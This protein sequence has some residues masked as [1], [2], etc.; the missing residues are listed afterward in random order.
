MKNKIFFKI[1]AIILT[2]IIV[3]AS[4]LIFVITPNLSE[5]IIDLEK[6]QAKTQLKRVEA[7]IKS[8]EEYLKNYRAAKQIEHKDNLRDISK[9]VSVLLD[10]YY[11]LYEEKL[12][13]KEEA[14]KKAFSTVSNIKY[15]YEDDYIYILDK[16]GKV[17]LH[18]QEKYLFQNVYDL[19]DKKEK[20]FIKKLIEDTIKH[21]EFF[22]NYDWGENGDKKSNKIA[23]S[24]YYKPFDLI[25]VSSI[26]TNDLE[27]ELNA[28]K[29][30]T[31]KDLNP[32]IQSITKEELGYVFIMDKKAQL[33]MHPN[34]NIYS[35]KMRDEIKRQNLF[36][37]MKTAYKEKKSLNYKWDKK[38]DF[39][40]FTYDKTAWIDY[41]SF[42]GWYISSSLYIDD[43]EK[44]AKE[45]DSFV[46]NISLGF[47]FVIGLLA[48]I[49]LK[50][51]LDPISVLT[52]NAVTAREGNL[53]VRNKIET[54]DELGILAKQFNTMLDSIENNTKN[55]EKKLKERTAEIEYKFYHDS[56]TG[57]PNRLL[58]LR[59]LKTYEFSA[60]NLIS[61]DD[62]DNIN[63][64]YGFEVGDKL[65]VEISK[66]LQN[67]ADKKNL[68]L[69]RAGSNT[70][71]LLDLHLENFIVYDRII[72]EIQT[73]LKKEIEIKSLNL[74]IASDI[75]VGT[76]ISQDRQLACANIALKEAK[77]KGKKFT[78][79][80]QTIDTKKNI[81]KSIYWKDEIKSALKEDRIIP[82][83]QPIFDKEEKIIKYEVLMRIEKRDKDEIYYISPAQFLYI[84]MQIKQY[85]SL[86]KRII[87]K[88]FQ[89]IDKID[90]D[91]SINISFNDIMNMEFIQF[92]KEK[93]D[94]LDVK[95]RK[96]IVFEILESENIT[97]YE[98][99][100]QFIQEYRKKGIRIAID[101]FGTGFSNFSY[102]L[103]IKPDYIK[104]DGSLIKEIDTDF[105]SYE[106]VK[107]I[108][109][110][111]KSL[112][113][114]VIAEYIHS[115]EVY[116]IVKKLG[117]DEFQGYYL[118]KPEN[119]IE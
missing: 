1:C 14:E 13:S 10:G 119:L 31:I 70:F 53:E 9:M 54:N 90:K 78:I 114:K 22:F 106:L 108:V 104:I 26:S 58:M 74:K 43:L 99:L 105:N 113:I 101:D 65:L 34:L 5:Y 118:G 3:Y 98:I 79:Y 56:L 55:L 39:E 32:L 85:F 44:R 41:N 36:E 97:D 94:A 48:I 8:K 77:K 25:I 71:A 17:L 38:A 100:T 20:L 103:K 21:G 102:I 117:V 15:G 19:K 96:K 111:S 63:E 61:I 62:L 52:K 72:N 76:S 16:K 40:N 37:K 51:L 4:F 18:P 83:F 84:A 47:I 30:K 92:I 35:K 86:S 67:F 116:E 59:E 81:E 23:Y 112:G 24:L 27:S 69:Y 33:V 68:F 49:F 29:Q 91:I 57:L 66:L 80:N 11:K 45:V 115:K 7:V 28:E 107:A 82:V 46:I 73:L 60:L 12:F 110:F 64:L 89:Y 95:N 93:I 109:S 2:L 75:T 88:S 50:R 42:F 87:K 6:K